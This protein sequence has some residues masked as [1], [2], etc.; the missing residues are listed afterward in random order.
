MRMKSWYEESVKRSRSR[1]RQSHLACT[2]SS[3]QRRISS[4]NAKFAVHGPKRLVRMHLAIQTT[5]LSEGSARITAVVPN[6]GSWERPGDVESIH[7]IQGTAQGLT[8]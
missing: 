4:L 2:H 8:G 1:I 7:G 6:K 3:L 5:C